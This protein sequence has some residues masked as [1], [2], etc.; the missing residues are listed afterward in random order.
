MTE[1]R[2][3]RRG[4]LSR[5]VATTLT[6]LLL[7]AGAVITLVPLLLPLMTALKT[8]HQYATGSP[9]ALP[10]PF[11][12]ENFRTL[13][14]DGIDFW[15]PMVVTVQVV[16]V[17]VVGQMLASILAAYA[18][19]TL[20][21]R[22]RE[23]LFWLYIATLMVPAVVTIIPL[24]TMAVEAGWKNSFAGLV[25]PFVLGSPYAVF[26]LRQN[27]RSTPRELLDAATLD[28]AGVL[29]RLWSVVLPM[30]RPIV[31]TLLLITVVT[32]WNNFLWPSII[33]PARE[34]RVVTTATTA[35]QTQYDDRIVPV[36]TA[37]V[38]AMAPL[39][40]LFLI[41]QKKITAAIGI[42]GL[43]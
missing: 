10:D 14:G 41:F 32:Q 8:E 11:T 33:A 42:T 19:A 38:V 7:V 16:A 9:L 20:E 24:Y 27:F 31:V 5:P 36:M 2:T 17:L 12:L 37:A 6:Y 1:T 23:A 15:I 21:F 28:G 30:N 43:R 25:V 29:R 39:I 34:W 22:G 3:R 40:V 26:L 35:M 4:P 18:F 13:F